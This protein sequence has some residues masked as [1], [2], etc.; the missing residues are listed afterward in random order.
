MLFLWQHFNQSVCSCTTESVC[1]NLRRQYVSGTSVITHA[2]NSRSGQFADRT[3]STTG[4]CFIVFPF[5]NP[6][7]IKSWH[8]ARTKC[9]HH[10]GDLA[11]NIDEVGVIVRNQ[12]SSTGVTD[13]KNFWI[14]LQYD[15]LV[16]INYPGINNAHFLMF[17]N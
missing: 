1:V 4:G 7:A 8:N 13:S 17:F 5:D 16:W 15:P 12:L 9:L 3:S 11:V 14:G 6:R 2:N 10:G